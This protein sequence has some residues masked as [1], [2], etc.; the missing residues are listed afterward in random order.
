MNTKRDLPAGLD[1]DRVRRVA[2]HYESQTE[3][4]AVAEDEEDGM[5]TM[6]IPS[7]LVPEI[8]QLLRKRHG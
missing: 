2:Q 8:R 7:E 5:V 1:A 3:D 4:Q 6:E